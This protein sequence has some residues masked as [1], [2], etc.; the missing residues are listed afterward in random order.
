MG[1]WSEMNLVTLARGELRGGETED[2]AGMSHALFTGTA[3]SV[4]A[5]VGKRSVSHIISYILLD[6]INQLL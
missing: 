4:Q 3:R 5:S 6:C 2:S 1:C